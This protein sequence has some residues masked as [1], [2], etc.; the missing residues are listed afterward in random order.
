MKIK[1]ADPLD[2]EI[3][4]SSFGIRATSHDTARAGKGWTHGSQYWCLGHA[5]QYHRLQPD[6]PHENSLKRRVG[7]AKSPRL[8][9]H[10]R[11][12]RL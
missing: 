2:L 7:G 3:A 11:R 6:A 1:T 9:D 4:A 8:F 10:L 5:Q 12:G